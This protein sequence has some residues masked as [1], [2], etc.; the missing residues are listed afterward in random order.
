ML[1]LIGTIS[2]LKYGGVITPNILSLL[3]LIFVVGLNFDLYKVALKSIALSVNILILLS[4][5]AI[6]LRLNPRNYFAS[7]EGYPV[8]FDFLGIP[9]RNYGVFSHPNVLGQ[10]AS[11]SILFILE[12]RK[13]YLLLI[14]PVICLLKCGSRTAIISI[15]VGLMIFLVVRVM[16]TRKSARIERI[17]NPIV[18]GFFFLGIFVASSFQFLSYI[19]F[20]DPGALTGRASIWQS[21]LS[22]FSDSRLNGLG[23]GWEERAIDAQ[24][25]NT[26]AV[27]SHNAILEIIFSA[28]I[29]GIII[30]LIMLTKSIVY[31]TRL[32]TIEK[33]ILPSIIVSGISEAYIDLQYPTIQTLIYFLIILGAHVEKREI[34]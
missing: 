7:S 2:A 30:F 19:R 20:L 21:S 3:L 5:V 15:L 29:I 31:Y 4:F 14:T 9:G 28:G 16:K 6:V 11:L 24:L 18:I 8:F 26:W 12:S 17:K 10:A 34:N 23:W 13:N 22:I 25:L 32:F 33:L 1:Y 27:S